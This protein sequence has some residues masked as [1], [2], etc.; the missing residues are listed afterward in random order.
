MGGADI[1]CLS[2]SLGALRLCRRDERLEARRYLLSLWIKDQLRH[3]HRSNL[4]AVPDPSNRAV[5]DSLLNSF[6]A[7]PK[8]GAIAGGDILLECAASPAPRSSVD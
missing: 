1:L 2:Y 4:E 7:E 6:P 3:N 5:P 8:A